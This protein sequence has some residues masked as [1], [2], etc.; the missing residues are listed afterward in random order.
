MFLKTANFCENH[1][2]YTAS[3]HGP[4]GHCT[5]YKDDRAMRPLHG[6]PENFRES[7]AMPTATFLEI[8]KGLC[9]D[10]IDSI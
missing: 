10:R 9:C 2:T 4:E 5:V 1:D 6:C 3:N 8:A 7:L